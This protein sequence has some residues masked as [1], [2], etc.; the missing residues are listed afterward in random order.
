MSQTCSYTG[1][2]GVDNTPGIALGLCEVLDE[3][4]HLH[5]TWLHMPPLLRPA[6]I[7]PC[8]LDVQARVTKFSV[9]AQGK[10]QA[11]GIDKP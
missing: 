4:G 2:A 9:W 6:I 10:W 8:L 5:L 7:L 3:Y 11:R 1:V